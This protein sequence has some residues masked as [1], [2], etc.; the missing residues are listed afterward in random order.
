MQKLTNYKELLKPRN[1]KLEILDE[2]RI[3]VKSLLTIQ[4]LKYIHSK[5]PYR[6]IIKL[7]L[8]KYKLFKKNYAYKIEIDYNKKIMIYVGK[9]FN[10][11]PQLPQKRGR[12]SKKGKY[13][14]LL[15]RMKKKGISLKQFSEVYNIPYITI[16]R[17]W[18]QLK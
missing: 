7:R 16:K 12:P 3:F 11:K 17:W 9:W 10:I 8:N 18:K 2:N 15:Y 13:L 4:A 1:L 5:Y 14:S 6:D